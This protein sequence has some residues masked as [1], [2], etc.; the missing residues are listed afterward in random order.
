MIQNSSEAE[1]HVIFWQLP[2]SGVVF[3]WLHAC[4]YNSGWIILVPVESMSLFFLIWEI[5]K[6]RGRKL[7]D[8]VKGARMGEKIW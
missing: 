6:L 5:V 2:A 4:E 7:Y 3:V 1:I 8:V